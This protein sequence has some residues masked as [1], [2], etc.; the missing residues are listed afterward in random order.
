M[1]PGSTPKQFVLIPVLI[2]IPTALHSFQEHN[3]ILP[4]WSSRR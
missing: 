1:Q 4:M 2:A 3:I